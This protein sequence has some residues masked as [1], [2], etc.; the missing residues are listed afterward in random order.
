MHKIS[1]T[2]SKHFVLHSIAEGIFAAIAEDGGSA[3]SNSGLIDLSGQI[4]V[5]DTFLTPQAAIDLRQLAS[6]M[7]GRTPQIVI[8]SHYHNDHIWGNQVFAPDA[9]IVSSART[10]DLIATAGMEE[11]QWYLS[12]SA[13]LLESLRAQRQN[14]NDEQQQKQL[15]SWI[16]YY[17]GLVEALPHLTVCMPSITFD[18]RL[19]IHGA[20]QTAELITFEGAHTESDIVLHLGQEGIVFMSDL[21]FVGCH[22][23]LADGDPLQLLKALREL[24]RLDATCFV[25]GHGP[26]GTIDDLKLLIEY[27]EHCLETARMLVEKGNADK[28]R[29]TE[30]KITESYQQ[31][32]LPQ[33]YQTNISFLCE[34]LSSANGENQAN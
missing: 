5:F 27:V 13:Q 8:N 14:A 28:D 20:K 22:P 7:L 1:Y 11:L 6:D 18:S 4:L 3:I 2:G 30:L 32:Q 24:S 23:Y 16:G 33:F 19:E 31:W 12:N 17:G 9:Q 10:R 15:L 25:P 21:L 34:Y 29:I 26:A